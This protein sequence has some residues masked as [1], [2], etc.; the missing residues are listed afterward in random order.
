MATDERRL[1]VHDGFVTWDGRVLELFWTDR[2]PSEW[3]IHAATVV[4]WEFKEHG[5]LLQLRLHLADKRNRWMPVLVDPRDVP[6]AEQIL[7]EVDQ[8]S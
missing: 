6:L 1:P 7:S 8:I 3:R 4:R 2:K 5:D